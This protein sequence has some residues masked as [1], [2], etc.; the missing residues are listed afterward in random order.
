V[1]VEALRRGASVLH[2]A[3]GAWQREGAAGWA[4]AQASAASVALLHRIC[5]GIVPFVSQQATA[6]GAVHV[7]GAG[8]MN[9]LPA[10]AGLCYRSVTAVIQCRQTSPRDS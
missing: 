3:G 1:V 6:V 10:A 2:P 8:A 5:S 4:G 9:R 7:A